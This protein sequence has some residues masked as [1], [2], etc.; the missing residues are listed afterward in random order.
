MVF[1]ADGRHLRGVRPAVK[2]LILNTEYPEFLDWLYT[3]HSGLEEKSYDE[4]LRVRNESLFGVAD[5]YSSNLRALRIG[6]GAGSDHADDAV[7]VH[8]SRR[9]CV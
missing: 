6:G 1:G 2:Y 5:F 3:R 9:D 8:R 4:Q 7:P